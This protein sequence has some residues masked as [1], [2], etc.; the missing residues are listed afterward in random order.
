MSEENLDK[1]ID[2]LESTRGSRI[3]AY[4]TSDRKPPLQA[5]IATDV[6]PIFYEH[7]K[8]IK[9]TEKIELFLYS[10]G[11]DIM[12]P[13][14]L[15]NLIREFSKT[16]N[17]LVPYKAHS[18][19]TMIA[20]GA[21]KIVMGGLG[22]LSPIDPNIGTPFNPPHPD[23]PNEPK[24]EISV[25]DVFG[26]INLAKEKLQ[27]T[28]QS[29]VVD[30]LKSLVDKIHPLAIGAVYRTHSL[31]RLLAAKLLSLHMDEEKEAE[32]INQIVKDLV[33]KLYYHNYLINREEAKKLGLKIESPSDKL[34]QLIW[35]LYSI[36]EEEMELGK[37][38]NP[39]QLI[40]EDQKSH[41]IDTYIACVSSK[42]LHSKY[43]KSIEFSR[44]PSQQLGEPPRIGVRENNIGWKSFESKKEG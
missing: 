23:V 39:L 11:G 2:S 43:L 36:Y 15:V 41:K 29:N 1:C 20:L 12:P 13:W 22:E 32:R 34:E 21:D 31:I 33:E 26:Y 19:A 44:F 17:V 38:F 14:R 10:T 16:F 24:I 25:E 40:P 30:V 18:A 35:D 5:K 9:K 27:I 7:L 6:I 37:A 4:V 8:R 42:G 3:L 28:E